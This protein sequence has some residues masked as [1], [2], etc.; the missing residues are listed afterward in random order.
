MS[1]DPVTNDY[2]MIHEDRYHIF[3]C[4]KCGKKFVDTGDK[5]ICRFCNLKEHSNQ[6]SGNDTIDLL[7]KEMQSKIDLS[8][9]VSF[10]WASYEEMQSKIDKSG[11]VAFEWVPYEELINIKEL[12][13]DDFTKIYSAKW[14]KGSLDCVAYDTRLENEKVILKCFIHSQT[15]FNEFINEVLYF[16]L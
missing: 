13:K 11:V 12:Y 15:N 3:Y 9:D 8:G 5:L 10:E 2:I 14:T 4:D 7:I 6:K 16:N 1:Q